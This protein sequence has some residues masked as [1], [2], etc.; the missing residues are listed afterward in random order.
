MASSFCLPPREADK[1][2]EALLAREIDVQKLMDMSSADRHSFFEKLVGE[3][4][5]GPVNSLF[6]S[7]TIL[8]DV[9]AGMERWVKKVM[10]PNDSPLKRDML[11]K[12]EKLD[13]ILNPA[14]EKAFLADLVAT[15]MGTKVTFEETQ[16][17][18]EL[19]RKAA[20]ERD[21]PQSNMAGMSNDYINAA[22]ALEHYVH[23]IEPTTVVNSI[24]KNL[25]I[26]GR[27]HLLMN[28]A[29]PV[30][31][32]V[33]QLV[34]S[35]M[36]VA[37]RRLAMQAAS[38][39][40]DHGVASTANTEAWDTFRKTGANT[41]LMEDYQ[42]TGKLGEKAN[43]DMPEG[44]LSPHPLLNKIEGGVRWY[45][46]KTNKIAIDLEHN[47]TF[48]KFY[49]KAFFDGLSITSTYLA[50]NE[51][52]AGAALKS[53]ATAI[54]TDAVKIKPETDSGRAARAAG[55]MQAARVTSINDTV[56]AHIAM[57]TKNGLNKA[58][59]GLG[60]ILMPIAKIPANIIW[61]GIENAGVGLGHG[62]YEIFKGRTKM[63]S[64]DPAIKME[65]LIQFGQGMQRVIRTVG[66]LAGAAFFASTLTKQDFKQDIYGASFVKIAG[67]W[68]NME[69]ISAISPALAGMMTIK[70]RSNGRTGAAGYAQMYLRGA[71]GALPNAPGLTDLA[72]FTKSLTS[73]GPRS[74][75]V[76]WASAF[77]ASRGVPAFVHS[78]FDVKNGSVELRDRGVNRLFF[79]AHGVET[80][81]DVNRDEAELRQA[82]ALA[83]R[84]Q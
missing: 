44:M 13:K 79:G 25:A 58:V 6:E 3:D 81:Q 82:K 50:K 33:G 76:N 64:E 72:D 30:K 75:A 43:F 84:A 15:K 46:E 77:V 2:R 27:N 4:Y 73:L 47:F 32:T 45:A 54:F 20:L 28:P 57:A 55:Q 8:K 56:V 31:T 19:A 67:L 23:S 65:G 21:K 18:T 49:Q 37:S 62:A 61:N 70:Q 17:V 53:R 22:A 34:N 7:K 11:S 71:G 59:P 40:V 24:G 36:D 78:F 74:G 10:G 39:A 68:I 9:Q 80:P 41:A 52:L 60:D 26:I 48:T 5:A 69:Y 51:G 14:E 66:V 29:T 63:A 12:I 1:F 42:D 38:S 16:R 83:R 35:A